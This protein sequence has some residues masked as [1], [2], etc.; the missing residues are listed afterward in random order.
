MKTQWLTKKGIGANFK[1]GD[2]FK[3]QFFGTYEKGRII[4]GNG[5]IMAVEKDFQ[6]NIDTGCPFY[7]VKVRLNHRSGIFPIHTKPLKKI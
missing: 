2:K 1:V 3:S 6:K 4:P 5:T 7:Y